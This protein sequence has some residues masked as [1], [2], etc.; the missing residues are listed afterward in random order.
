MNIGLPLD[1]QVAVPEPNTGR[2]G[3]SIAQSPSLRQDLSEAEDE[4]VEEGE[5][6]DQYLL[7]RPTIRWS[8]AR[9]PSKS[10]TRPQSANRVNKGATGTVANQNAQL[11]KANLGTKNQ[12]KRDPNGILSSWQTSSLLGKLLTNNPMTNALQET[13]GTVVKKTGSIVDGGVEVWDAALEN[14][15]D[16]L[17]DAQEYTQPL[18]NTPIAGSFVKPVSRATFNLLDGIHL[19]IGDPADAVATRLRET[20]KSIQESGKNRRV[21]SRTRTNTEF[22]NMSSLPV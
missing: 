14:T 2:Q 21:L 9:T 4:A 19:L 3:S 1:D 20:G 10:D 12:V 7:P 11:K 17:E 18:Q 6:E 15:K 8:P 13:V 5:A 16:F 22:P